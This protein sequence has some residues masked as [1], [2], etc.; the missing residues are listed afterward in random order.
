MGETY[1][2]QAESIKCGKGDEGGLL[3]VL[4][5]PRAGAQAGTEEGKWGGVGG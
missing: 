2:Y 3:R 1:K 5:E 4:W